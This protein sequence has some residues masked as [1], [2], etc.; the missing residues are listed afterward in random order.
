MEDNYGFNNN[1]FQYPSFD[2]PNQFQ[3][4]NNLQNQNLNIPNNIYTNNN[5]NSSNN[6]NSSKNQL[7]NIKVTN[8]DIYIKNQKKN[9][10]IRIPKIFDIKMFMVENEYEYININ[11]IEKYQ[12]DSIL[13]ILDLNNNNKY[14][15]IVTS[16][17]V[18]AKVLGSFLFNIT[19]VELIKI[20]NN[21]ESPNEINNINDIKNLFSTKN[22]YFSN[23]FDLSL[24]LYSQY[25]INNYDYNGNNSNK[26]QLK[27]KYLINSSLLKYFVDN[28]I[29]ECF[30]S[31]IIYGYVGCKID[32]DLDENRKY[33]TVDIIIIERYYK[34][35]IIINNDIPGYVKEIELICNFK[36]KN[37]K[38]KNVFSFV[39]YIN[40]ESMPKINEFDICKNILIEEFEQYK[41][42]TCIINNFNNINDKM[43]LKNALFKFNEKFFNNKIKLVD[44]TS[45]WDK[46]LFFDTNNDSYTYINFFLNNSINEIQK[47]AFWFI[48]INNY[49][50]EDDSCFNAFIRI[51]WKAIQKEINFLG[52]DIDIGLF[53]KNNNSILCQKY[54]EIIMKYH[55]DLDEN[56]KQ[57]Y[58]NII[59]RDK[60]Q[61]TFIN[62]FNHNYN[63]RNKS[64]NIPNTYRMH[65]HSNSNIINDNNTSRNIDSTYNKNIFQK[66][67]DKKKT[68]NENELKKIKVLC[69]TWN[70]AGISYKSDYN[71]TEL[72][73]QNIF[74]H[75]KAPP[76][77]IVVAIQEIIKLSITSVLSIVSNQENVKAWTDNILYTIN[78]VYP[79][80]EYY[81]LKCMDLVGIYI[82]ILIKKELRQNIYVLDSNTTKTGIYGTMGN[83]G[84]FTITLKCYDTF[85]AFGSGHFEAGQSKNEDR[86]DTLNQLLNK[87]LNIQNYD[88]YLTFK[89]IE[90]W[91]ILGDLN[92]RIDLNF[93][94]AFALIKEKKYDI[95]YGLDQFNSSMQINKFFSDNINE[96]EIKFDPTYKYVK[97]SNEYAYDEDKIRVPA[98]T[99]RIFYCKNKGIKMLTYDSIKNMRYSDHRPVVG[100][101]LIKCINKRSKSIKTTNRNVNIFREGINNQNINRNKNDL[102]DKDN[103]ISENNFFGGINKIK[104]NISNNISKNIQSNSNKK[105]N[106]KEEKINMNYR[107]INFNTEIDLIDINNIDYNNRG[108]IKKEENNNDQ[109]IYQFFEDKHKN[110]N[111]SSSLPYNNN[112]YNNS[113]NQ[114]LIFD[115]F[116]NINNNN[117]NI[118]NNNDKDLILDF[119]NNDFGYNNQNIFGT[120][121][122]NSNINFQNNNYQNNNFQNNNNNNNNINFNNIQDNNNIFNF[123]Q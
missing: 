15:V 69:V 38:T 115:S 24:S 99:D 105:S 88:A 92:F 114:N 78:K 81:Q 29:P 112:N 42:I 118:N 109:D 46:N 76:D 60:I 103:Q 65:G 71:I 51:M 10:I 122:E 31:T 66:E 26:K 49:F 68:E 34:K 6:N 79:E 62:C 116:I 94:D 18:A 119:N 87:Q 73:T 110:K 106:R 96:K 27:S 1:N 75:K 32:V 47:S 54:K 33:L 98:W 57:L 40:S 30:Y 16:S 21:N 111:N 117:N 23:D 101:F 41:N 2:L 108:H 19:S 82:L 90:N 77:I 36:N 39:F 59:N 97:G 85:I 64:N 89:D 35:N 63:T 83:K 113:Q 8:T 7:Y 102:I 4:D 100:T 55:N 17:K 44:F 9:L 84:F 3:N 43:N 20:S 80:V 56:K 58:N 37:N 53:N 93:E 28:S 13:G 70:I 11:E 14:L 48:D 91:I 123:F 67:N 104:K 61:E 45:D 86:I 5:Y 120:N 95:L 52:L 50:S 121:S 12:A 107:G 22:F 25:K 72:F 74:Y